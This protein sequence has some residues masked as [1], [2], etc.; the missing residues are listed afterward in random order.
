M[1][2]TSQE[3]FKNEN[4]RNYSEETHIDDS[5]VNSRKTREKETDLQIV[6]RQKESDRHVV[7][8]EKKTDMQIIERLGEIEKQRER[9]RYVDNK[10]I[11]KNVDNRV[12]ETK[13]QT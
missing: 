1:F 6:R 5:H 4:L 9:D 13:R 3:F 8:K 10:D 2:V 11:D 12:T 7:K